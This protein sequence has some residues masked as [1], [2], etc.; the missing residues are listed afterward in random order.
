PSFGGGFPGLPPDLLPGD[1][2]FPEGFLPPVDGEMPED[3]EE[4]D[5]GNGDGE[6][7]EDGEEGDDGEMPEEDGEEGDDG[8]GE[9]PPDLQFP[10]GFPPL[11][12]LPFPE[13]IG[14][15]PTVE[16]ELIIDGFIVTGYKDITVTITGEDNGDDEKPPLFP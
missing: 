15:P 12:G 1:L 14:P 8:D 7:P 9:I 3:G 11:D 13:D 6:M 2:P 5:N 10:E 4:G 16:T